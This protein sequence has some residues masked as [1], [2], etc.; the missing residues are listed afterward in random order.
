MK[1]KNK[2]LI[3][4]IS[5]VVFLLI[6][7]SLMLFFTTEPINNRV[8]TDINSFN[9]LDQYVTKDFDIANDKKLNGLVPKQSYTKEISYNGHVYSVYAYVFS[10]TATTNSYFKSCTG[11]NTNME[12]N[13]SMS[14]NVL[15]SSDYIAYSGCYVYRIEGNSYKEFVNAV[16][17]INDSFP[18]DLNTINS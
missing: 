1:L 6:S 17:F 12:Y 14:T 10:D 7:L 5:N 2:I 11:K 4:I 15:F 13:F 3:I 9:K 16:N 8:F 18:I